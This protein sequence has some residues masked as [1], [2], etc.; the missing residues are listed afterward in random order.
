MLQNHIWPDDA[1]I[2]ND[3]IRVI[4]RTKKKYRIKNSE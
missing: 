3:Y 4:N 1:Y 2:N